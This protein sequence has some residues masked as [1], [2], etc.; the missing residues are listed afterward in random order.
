M[1]VIVVDDE[2]SALHAFLNEIIEEYD[3]DYKFYKDDAASVCKYV[4][5][6]RVDAAFFG[7]QHAQDK[8]GGTCGKVVGY[9]PV[10]ENCVYN[11]AFRY[12]RGTSARCTQTHG[13]I[14][15]QALQRGKTWNTAFQNTKQKTCVE[16]GNV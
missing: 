4:A 13:G 16:S 7:H 10:A 12:G 15:V 6:N 11:G 5:E 2:M 8:R 14:F 9:C 1:K 3:V